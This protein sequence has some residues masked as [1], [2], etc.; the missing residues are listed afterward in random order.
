MKIGC[1]NFINTNLV[2]NSNTRNSKNFGQIKGKK[3]AD[4]QFGSSKII[5]K[6]AKLKSPTVIPDDKFTHYANTILL[7][8]G[9]TNKLFLAPDTFLLNG[10]YKCDGTNYP[11]A[12]EMNNLAYKASSLIST[13]KSFENIMETIANG[14]K[15]IYNDDAFGKLTNS[16]PPFL[17]YNY[18][19]GRE[20]LDAYHD[21]LKSRSK[22]VYTGYSPNA[23]FRLRKANVCQNSKNTHPEGIKIAFPKH[24]ISTNLELVKDE[25]E[26]LK[27]LNNPSIDKINKSIATMHW[28]MA[29]ETPYE[30]GSNSI[31]NILTKSIYHSYGIKTGPARY[32]C[33]FDFEAFYRDLNEFVSIY[34]YLFEKPPKKVL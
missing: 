34:P 18:S 27:S 25:Y 17:M 31:A 20:Y 19:R 3:L 14:I 8:S 1:N 6:I 23:N 13:D 21:R 16:R 33:S 9:L 32:G 10:L 24:K 7:A 5:T 26:K 15:E 12:K 2:H 4:A 29:Q 28:L 22:S 11:W 30:R